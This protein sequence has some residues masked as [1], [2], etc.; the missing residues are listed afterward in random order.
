MDGETSLGNQSKEWIA[1]TGI[2]VEKSAPYIPA[3]NGSAKRPGVVIIQ[4]SRYMRIRA[5]LPE[6]LWPEIVPAT[7]C[8]ANR[9]PSRQQK[10]K[11][12]F[13]ILQQLINIPNPCPNIPHLKVYG[14]RQDVLKPKI[15]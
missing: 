1:E 5:R 11:G 6:D 7:A 10:W 14:C 12:S 13:E 8:I 3:Q 15:P 9:S 2:T 4:K